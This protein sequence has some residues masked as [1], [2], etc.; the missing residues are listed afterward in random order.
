VIGNNRGDEFVID[1]WLMSCRVL[2]RQVEEEVLNEI[3]RLAH[4]RGCVRIVGRYIPSAKNGM[5]QDLYPRLG[6]LCSGEEP[7]LVQVYQLDVTEYRSIS[8][9]I[10]VNRDIYATAGSIH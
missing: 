7:G 4:D 2:K 8:T 5:V 3:V 10:N 6:F 9:T 1:T